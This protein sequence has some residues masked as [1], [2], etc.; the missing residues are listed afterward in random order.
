MS[1]WREEMTVQLQKDYDRGYQDGLSDPNK[2]IPEADLDNDWYWNGYWAARNE[3]E[4]V[5]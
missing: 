2:E 4:E 5:Q 3:W 1:D